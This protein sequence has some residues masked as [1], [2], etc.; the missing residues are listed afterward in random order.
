[1]RRLTSRA[2]RLAALP[3]LA[4][5]MACQTAPGGSPEDRCGAD[6]DP[7]AI[8]AVAIADGTLSA[9]DAVCASEQRIARTNWA[10]NAVIASNPSAR[11]EAAAADAA[12]VR[13]DA[14]PLQGVPIL[15]KDNIE[16]RELPTTAGSLALAANDTGRD[17][18]AIARLRAAG[19]IVLGKAN[20]SEWA[21]F[22]DEASVS[23]WSAVGGQ[24]RN[25]H[26]LERSPCGSSSGSGA[27]VAAGL[28]PAAL[29]TETNG[30]II[31][32]AA[33]NGIVGFKP[34][35]GFV[36]RHR[37]VPISPTQDTIG[38]MTRTVA[39]AAL[40]LSV[41]AGTDP[42]DPATAQADRHRPP[43]VLPENALRGM[44]VGV[45][46]F[47]VGDDP[48]IEVRFEEALGVL[49]DRGARLVEVEAWSP[50]EGLGADE[51]LVLKAE[52]K[53]ALNAYLAEAAPGVTVRTLQDLI[54]F[55]EEN[56]AAEL[57]L[58]GQDILIASEET[59]GTDDPAYAEALPRLL[60]GTRAD[61][62]EA[63]FARS[64][65]DVLVAPSL[66]PAFLIDPV[67]G[68][69]YRGGVGL[70]WLAAIAGTPHLTVPM[71][72]ANGLPVGLSVFGPAW[73]D[74]RVL[75]AGA[76]YEAGSGRRIAP[77]V[78]AQ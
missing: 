42:D 15:V 58:F 47:A 40:L 7:D 36:S 35:V 71:G 41:M 69:D 28:A 5:L 78:P 11:A 3:P 70:G 6:L 31:C 44:T 51:F 49:R 33:A 20:L 76:D 43:A 38:P 26:A 32:P 53:T 2:S 62:I 21:N 72:A 17:A 10:L 75:A 59:G 63:L 29:G 67:H 56:A 24:T 66:R 73:S 61:G 46:R 25:P 34:T 39:D 9:E 77:P 52:F 37:V 4:A 60:R 68:D 18:P 50:Y 64:G 27:A 16:T 54:V 19:A 12:R 65:A 13:G 57:P 23:G 22:R 8:T 1:M 74:A 30:S 55:N 48:E 14:G 45:L